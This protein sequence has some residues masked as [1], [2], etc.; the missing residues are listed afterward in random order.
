MDEN[1]GG[2]ETIADWPLTNGLS[3]SDIR[4]R[5]AAATIKISNGCDI[6]LDGLLGRKQLGKGEI[7]YCQIDPN[8]FNADSLTYFRFTRWPA[9][10]AF[11]QVAAN[12]G[13]SFT[14]DLNIFKEEKKEVTYIDLVKPSGKR[15]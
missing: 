12:L 14:C 8:R 5:T 2:G 7:I 11:A 1:F 6:S 15:K 13:A 10:R 3:I 4:Y 9:T